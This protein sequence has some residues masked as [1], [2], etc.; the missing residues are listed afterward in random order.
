[1]TGTWPWTRCRRAPRAKSELAKSDQKYAR[2]GPERTVQEN[3]RNPCSQLTW[4]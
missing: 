2:Q 4:K 3:L 1:M